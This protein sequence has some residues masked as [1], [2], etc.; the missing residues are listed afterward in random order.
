[1]PEKSETQEFLEQLKTDEPKSVEEVL[2]LEKPQ[3]A[4]VPAKEEEKDEEEPYKNRKHRRWEARLSEKEKELIAKEARIQALEEVNARRATEDA[5]SIDPRLT[6]LFGTEGTGPEAAALFQQLLEENRIKAEERALEKV[7]AE[8]QAEAEA[9]SEAESELD[10]SFEALEDE[11]G[12]DF[13]SNAPAARKARNEMLT[14][15][16]KF[17]P[18]DDEGNILEYADIHGV[19]EVWQNQRSSRPTNTRRNELASRSMESGE[20]SEGVNQPKDPTQFSNWRKWA[21]LE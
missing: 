8:R 19:Y 4:E 2:G 16:E 12:I 1:M 10:S 13:T 14:L 5:G 7:L 11:A 17:S 15:L 21:G 9:V 20:S 18:K 3:T 6:K